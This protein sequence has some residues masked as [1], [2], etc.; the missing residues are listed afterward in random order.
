MK[1]KINTKYRIFSKKAYI[2][3]FKYNSRLITLVQE[4]QLSTLLM[5]VF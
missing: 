5:D 2:N 4:R 3:I 1:R